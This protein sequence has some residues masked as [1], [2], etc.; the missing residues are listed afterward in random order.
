MQKRQNANVNC[1]LGNRN[2]LKI[3]VA[4]ASSGSFERTFLNAL[5]KKKKKD[6]AAY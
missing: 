3:F 1:C 4:P 5:K 2:G 6:G